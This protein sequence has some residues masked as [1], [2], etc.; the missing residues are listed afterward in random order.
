[1]LNL[2]AWTANH[3]FRWYFNGKGVGIKAANSKPNQEAIS[4]DSSVH[5]EGR[6]IADYDRADLRLHVGWE[7]DVGNIGKGECL[8]VDDGLTSDNDLRRRCIR[9]NRDRNPRMCRST[10]DDLSEPTLSGES[11]GWSD[12]RSE[13]AIAFGQRGIGRKLCKN[14]S[15]YHAP[16]YRNG[17][18]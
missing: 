5:A 3:R 4:I 9:G 8:G 14:E 1:M 18:I 12:G 13:K 15:P 2:L 17:P 10:R 6:G 11:Q 16:R 7:P